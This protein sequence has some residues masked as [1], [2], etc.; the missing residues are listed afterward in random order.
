LNHK[1]EVNN[2]RTENYLLP[3]RPLG[4]LFDDIWRS[5]TGYGSGAFSP[6]SEIDET[7]S[8]YLVSI[9]LPG[10]KKDAISIELKDSVLSVSG[11]RKTAKFQRSFS[12][13]STVESERIEADYEDGV[14]RI[15]IPKA[16]EIKPRQIKIGDGKNG[17]LK[18][19]LGHDGKSR[20]KEAKESP[21][22]AHR[23]A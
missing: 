17:F 16:E 23:A 7:D 15:A 3:F 20:E 4:E 13:P 2:M 11:E 6:Q 10:I 5:S 12:L 22:D 8:H 19:F 9:D 14:L 1:K 18:K 21:G